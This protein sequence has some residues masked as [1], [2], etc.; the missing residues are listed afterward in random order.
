MDPGAS[1]LVWLSNV[2]EGQQSI[3]L[4]PVVADP[5]GPIAGQYVDHNV[6]AHLGE[7]VY[8]SLACVNAQEQ[9]I[10]GAFLIKIPMKETESYFTFSLHCGVV[11]AAATE[12]EMPH[13]GPAGAA[14]SG[15]IAVLLLAAGWGFLVVSRR[16]TVI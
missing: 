3:T 15:A 10:S 5:A 13:T 14:W 6:L 4:L 16:R 1:S 8:F 9:P 7:P 11:E 12:A 2:G